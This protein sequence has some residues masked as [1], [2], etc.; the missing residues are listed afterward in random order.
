MSSNH[1]YVP[2]WYQRLFL[3]AGEGELY[4]LNKS[5][6]NH[7]WCS[8]GKRRSIKPKSVFKCG[9]KK[10]FSVKDLYSVQLMGVNSD[11]IER[12]FFG[13]IDDSGARAVSTFASWPK[14][15]GYIFYENDEFTDAVGDPNLHMQN[16]LEFM[17]TQKS[18]TPR[19]IALIKKAIVNT[20]ARF[21]SQNNV[22]GVLMRL[23]AIRCTVWSESYWEIFSVKDPNQ[24]FL[25]S[26]D[27]VTLYNCDCFPASEYCQF[28]NDPNIF[29][30]GTRVLYPLS[31]TKLLV[32]THK[33]HA[34]SPLRTK[35]RR[36]RIHARAFDKA[37]MSWLEVRNERE[38]SR[39]EVDQINFVIKARAKRFVASASEADLFPERR[40]WAWRWPEIDSI[41]RLELA[42]GVS[43]SH[44]C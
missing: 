35:A 9:A 42:P 22:I 23:R 36:P 30:R 4:V 21:L 14:A 17:D 32:L 1:H 38:L 16:L 29:W 34:E 5:P 18:R 2:Q 8:D 12:L 28:P 37:L 31:P 6:E 3:A 39:E 33:E 26:D 13:R 43:H 7:K 27:P 19:G 40:R 20:D 25:L 24:S 15:N 10:L 11:T 41:F 44:R